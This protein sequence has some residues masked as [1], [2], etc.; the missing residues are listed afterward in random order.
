MLH[1]VTLGVGL[2][3]VNG[4]VHPPAGLVQREITDLQPVKYHA[5]YLP[6]RADDPPVAGI[7]GALRARLSAQ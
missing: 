1:F 6:G 3:V 4:C 7:L 5:M 2:A